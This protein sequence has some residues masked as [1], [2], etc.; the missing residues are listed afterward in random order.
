MT[1]IRV[2]IVDDSAVSRRLVMESFA[3]LP[4]QVV[5]SAPDGRLALERIARLN[6]NL[7]TLDVQM[8]GMDGVATM[9]AIRAAH[10]KLKVIMVSAHTERGAQVTIDAL[11]SGA[12]DYITKPP[13]A[14]NWPAAVEELRAQLAVK[15][16]QLFQ[17]AGELG[18]AAPRPVRTAPARP[19]A[20]SRV[21]IVAMG[22]S[23]GGPSALETVLAALPADF[24]A[25]IVI[26]QHM[27]PLFT[28]Y[29]AERLASVARLPVR[30]AAGGEILE[31]PAAWLAPGDFH[32][33]LLPVGPTARVRVHQSEPVNSCRP[34]VDV[35]FGSVA[36]AYGPRALAV[37]LTGM[38][39]DGLEGCKRLRAAGG[40]I[41][42]QDQDSSVV[43]GM[44]GNVA[45]QGVADAVLALDDLAP[46]ILRRVRAAR[47]LP[48][49]AGA[50]QPCRE[51]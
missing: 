36:E 26:V 39:N 16:K 13:S 37:V 33:S 47:N 34:S 42:V 41:L 46:E 24:P 32:M 5:G 51:S 6:P 28:R 4:A 44:P 31:P 35:L 48:P 29:L 20:P 21:D 14:G 11:A 50:I 2:F 3:G 17:I 8:P 15:L 49:T 19:A 45:T 1:A 43:W 12:A 7:V 40:Q 9:A 10:P 18:P 22:V 27:P 30:E 23:T 38:G 25:P